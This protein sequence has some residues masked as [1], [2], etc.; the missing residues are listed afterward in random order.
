MANAEKMLKAFSKIIGPI[1]G[2]LALIYLLICQ[3][4]L[5]ILYPIKELSVQIPFLLLF[6]FILYMLLIDV[7]QKQITF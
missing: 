5:A 6:E 7:Y 4:S 1:F 2:I 3:I